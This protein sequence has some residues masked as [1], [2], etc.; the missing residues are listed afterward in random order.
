MSSHQ[1]EAMIHHLLK[2][3]FLIFAILDLLALSPFFSV[4]WE[5]CRKVVNQP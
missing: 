4:W 5:S 3:A 1:K 2:K